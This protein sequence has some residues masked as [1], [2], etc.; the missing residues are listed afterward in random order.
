LKWVY[1]R[2]K[3]VSNKTLALFIV[4][5]VVVSLG[6]TLLSLNKLQEISRFQQAPATKEVTGMASSAGKVELTI[7]TNASCR[8]ESNVS[9]GSAGQQGTTFLLSSER[10]NDPFN[11]CTSGTSCTGLQVNNTGNVNL[12][13][14]MTSNVTGA[15]LL[16]GQ[17]GAGVEDFQYTVKSGIA[18][19]TSAN[20][21]DSA[22]YNLVPLDYTWGNVAAADTIICS[23]ML[24]G[25][26]TS[27]LTLEYNVTIEPSLPPGPRSAGIT[28]E[29][30][31]V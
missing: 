15:T 25:R 9:F 7:T 13:V 8:I 2:K 29:C 16:D 28:I 14:N 26:D 18:T 21:T 22:C 5:T 6:G 12:T 30:E 27:M 17:V 1:R 31:Q 19:A 11:D 24:F 3:M 4:A 20:G 23:R 10:D